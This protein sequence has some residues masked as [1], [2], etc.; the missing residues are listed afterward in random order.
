MADKENGNGSGVKLGGM[1]LPIAVIG[2]IVVQAFGIIW[3]V[4]NLDS[5][6]KNMQANVSQ[7]QEAATTVDVAV[8]Q[9]DIVNLKEKI[10]MMDEMH[11]E[12]FDPA[13]IEQDIDKLDEELH[14]AIDKLKDKLDEGLRALE[15]QGDFR[16]MDV[17][18]DIEVKTE[19]VRMR[20]AEL[21]TSV[22][23][24]RSY[25]DMRAGEADNNARSRVENL[26]ADLEWR[27]EEAEND[28]E[29]KLSEQGMNIENMRREVDDNLGWRID[30][31]VDD[32]RGELDDMRRNLEDYYNER[33]SALENTLNFSLP[34]LEEKF[35]GLEGQVNYNWQDLDFQ[36]EEL[37]D[38]QDHDRQN[39]T[40]GF[41]NLAVAA[42]DAL[43]QMEDRIEYAEEA[44]EE[45]IRW[46]EQ[47]VAVVENEM[48]TIMS[49]HEQFNVILREMGR[50]GYGDNRDYGDYEQQSQLSKGATPVALVEEPELTEKQIARQAERQAEREAKKEAEEKA[51]KKA[52]RQAARQENQD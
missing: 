6:V 20:A 4:A 1:K 21:T 48:R 31:R 32:L 8:M 49:D 13:P 29:F 26:Q 7:M 36:I 25:V 33:F 47:I 30:E 51:K 22:G 24:I 2:V 41:A 34:E 35:Y 28:I 23:E 45:R 11:G 42:R 5:T 3:Y 15:T 38:V 9:A 39:V 40:T 43:D 12:K 18:N 16:L 50:E 10:I 17:S 44:L 52:E 27:L 46:I 14:L 19:D 37:A